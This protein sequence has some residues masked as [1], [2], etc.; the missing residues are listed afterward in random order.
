MRKI[1]VLL[2][3]A[4]ALVTACKQP[5]PGQVKVTGGWI[6]G[7]VTEDMCIYKGIPFA[8]PPVGDLRWKEPQPVIP[9][10]GVRECLEFGPGPVQGMNFPGSNNSEDCLY[11]NVWSPAKSPKDKMPV[12]VWIYG[13]GFSM[14]SSS[15]Y[16]GRP[17]AEKGVILV[18]IN[19]RVGQLGY[20]AHPELTAESP[21]VSGNYGIMDQ[22]AALQ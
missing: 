12:F 15:L 18:T 8:A 7:E 14:G 21:H 3:A 22:I 11:L 17:L 4:V 9:W 2:L 19:Y 20:F 1:S 16:D 5:V 13:G 10:E 6:Q